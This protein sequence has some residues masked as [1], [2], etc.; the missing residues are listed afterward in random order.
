MSM[1]HPTK[2]AATTHIVDFYWAPPKQGRRVV[3]WEPVYLLWIWTQHPF[4]ILDSW[5]MQNN[6]N[7]SKAEQWKH[8]NE[9]N[10]IFIDN[11][12]KTIDRKHYNT[13]VANKSLLSPLPNLLLSQHN[14]PCL[15]CALPLLRFFFGCEIWKPFS[16][17]CLIDLPRIQHMAAFNHSPATRKKK[18]KEKIDKQ[19]R[20]T[21]HWPSSH[22]CFIWGPFSMLTTNGGADWYIPW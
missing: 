16:D 10:C 22:L 18:E 2:V 6:S 7:D 13:A 5:W 21:D 12:Q 8:C 3:V 1:L 20:W 14:F 4:H 11:N 9:S 15:A 17:Q 19:N